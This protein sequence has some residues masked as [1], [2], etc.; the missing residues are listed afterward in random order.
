MGIV[1]KSLIAASTCILAV[2]AP[3]TFPI[4]AVVACAT[5]KPSYMTL[6]FFICDIKHV[7]VFIFEA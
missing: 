7:L 1:F 4:F 6:P 5:R 2:A 3:L